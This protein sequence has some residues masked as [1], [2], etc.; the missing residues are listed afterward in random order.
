MPR[1]RTCANSRS[2]ISAARGRNVHPRRPFASASYGEP[3]GP[4]ARPKT[5]RVHVPLGTANGVPRNSKRSCRK[6]ATRP[7]TTSTASVGEQLGVAPLE[8]VAPSG[9]A[10]LSPPED[11]RRPPAG[12]RGTR[13]CRSTSHVLPAGVRAHPVGGF[14]D[15]GRHEPSGATAAPIPQC[16]PPGS[17]RARASTTGVATATATASAPTRRRTGPAHQVEKTARAWPRPAVKRV[18][19]GVGE[20]AAR[21]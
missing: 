1:P 5:R 4:R 7:A 12:C 9:R 20:I 8:S 13:R 2:S 6:S 15:P 11:R 3:R 21:R 18:I 17:S 16:V 10:K 14:H 19:G